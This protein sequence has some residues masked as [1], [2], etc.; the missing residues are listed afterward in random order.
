MTGEHERRKEAALVVA[1][2]SRAPRTRS[3]WSGWGNARNDTAEYGRV[4]ARLKD[5][6]RPVRPAEKKALH[7]PG[8]IPLFWGLLDEPELSERRPDD[9]RRRP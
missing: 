9:E 3:S 8:Q 6:M 4:A 7:T 2:A 1:S 5:G